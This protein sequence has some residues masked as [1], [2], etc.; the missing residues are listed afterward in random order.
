MELSPFRGIQ[1]A[2]VGLLACTNYTVISWKFKEIQHTLISSCWKT[3]RSTSLITSRKKK[4][5][6]PVFI[7]RNNLWLYHPLNTLTL[8]SALH[9][10]L[11]HSQNNNSL[12]LWPSS[13]S[14]RKQWPYPLIHQKTNS[15]KTLSATAST[16]FIKRFGRSVKTG[17]SSWKSV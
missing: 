14:S 1:V 11:S 17:E 16:L 7:L 8:S 5:K 12:V 10:Y 9:L 13:M 6:V 2:L 15:S 4:N 3:K